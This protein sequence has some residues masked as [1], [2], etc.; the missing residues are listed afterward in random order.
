MRDLTAKELLVIHIEIGRP[1]I[2]W[3]FGRQLLEL[4]ADHDERLAPQTLSIWNDHI[5]DVAGVADAQPHWARIGTMRISGALSAF[6]VGLGWQR[7]LTNRYQAEI[8]HESR[9]ARGREV[10]AKLSVY[11][12]PHKAIDWLGFAHRLYAVTEAH[13]AFVHLHRDAHLRADLS[14]AREPTWGTDQRTSTSVPQLGWSTFLGRPYADV[15][16]SLPDLHQ[17][18]T[19]AKTGNGVALTLT[20]SILDVANEY[21]AFDATRSNVKSMFPKGFFQI[22]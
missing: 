8:R 2:D 1:T 13:Y 20:D 18:V 5:A 10:P 15:A 7:T 6:H 11:A 3:A 17:N 4:F 16:S 14:A 19:I 9:T 21:A 22:A 12:K